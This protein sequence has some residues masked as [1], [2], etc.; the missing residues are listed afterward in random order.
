MAG[1]EVQANAIWTAMQ[2]LPLRSAP[3]WVDLLVLVLLAV[4]P[5]LVRWRLPLGV[6]GALTVVAGAAFLV[7]AQLAFEAGTI[8]DVA[9][10]L[11]ALIVGAFGAI[12]GAS[13]PSAGSAT[14]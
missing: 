8:V 11:L 14:A 3:P 4:L 13:S 6:V 2:G 5:P 10:P 9:A 7:A 12:A 1:A